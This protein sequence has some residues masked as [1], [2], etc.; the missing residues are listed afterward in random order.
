MQI[1]H[2]MRITLLLTV[3][4]ISISVL[5]NTFAETAAFVAWFI[6]MFASSPAS[7]LCHIAPIPIAEEISAPTPKAHRK[8]LPQFLSS[9]TS[10]SL[11][12]QQ[13]AGPPSFPALFTMNEGQD[14]TS[15]TQSQSY[16]LQ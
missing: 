4:V 2:D 9:L 15:G 7:I 11:W 8:S 10:V 1:F 12:F 16:M 6:T 13:V 3:L 5:G 14:K